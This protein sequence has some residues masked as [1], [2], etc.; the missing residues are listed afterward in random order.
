MLQPLPAWSRMRR[1]WSVSDRKT[2]NFL[3][4][5]YN[6]QL[7]QSS[8][9]PHWS[10]E[11]WFCSYKMVQQHQ[12]PP[13]HP[14]KISLCSN[15]TGQLWADTIVIS[16]VWILLHPWPHNLMS[17]KQLLT[18]GWL[19]AA[20]VADYRKAWC[21]DA[22]DRSVFAETELSFLRPMFGVPWLPPEVITWNNKN[23]NA[24]GAAAE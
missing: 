3:P 17:H 1:L 4:D 6:R 14:T 23:K 10:S 2:T 13:P 7:P 18:E 8:S 19:V 5:Y 9:S 22:S 11:F 12:K 20:W 24:E 16:K 21:I 15:V